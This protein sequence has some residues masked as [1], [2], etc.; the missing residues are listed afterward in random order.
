ME[1]KNN[2]HVKGIIIA[3]LLVIGIPC[4]IPTYI[5]GAG[6][7]SYSKRFC[8][9]DQRM[10]IGA[11]EMYNMDNNEWIKHCDDK[12]IEELINKKYLRS[13][14]NKPYS[15]YSKCKYH[16]KGDLTNDGVLYCEFHGTLNQDDKNSIPPSKE[17]F[18][19][20][21]RAEIHYYLRQYGPISLVVF[22]V[23]LVAWLV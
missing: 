13:N 2:N 21:R 7:P 16:N 9:S 14:F 17:Y 10:I 15:R 18:E 22:A 19:T 6:A 5:K 8:D 20:L 1:K 12:V 11:I 3:L 4:S 23:V